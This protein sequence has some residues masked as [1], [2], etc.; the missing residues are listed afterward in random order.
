MRFGSFRYLLKEG[1]R[2]L[3]AN[4]LMSLA[5]VGVLFACLLM[6]GSFILLTMNM[7]GII[8]YMEDQ[9][10]VI[11]FLDDGLSGERIDGIGQQLDLLDNIREIVFVSREEGLAQQ[12]EIFGDDREY[13]QALVDEN[14]IP[15][16][17]RIQIDDLSMLDDTLAKIGRIGGIYEVSAP[18]DVAVIVSTL[19][20]AV[21]AIGTAIIAVLGIVSLLIV[22]NTIKIT[23]FNRR[24]EINIMKYVGATNAF[25]RFP[26]LIEGLLLGL[27]A[28]LLAYFVLFLG[29]DTII[30]WISGSAENWIGIL[31]AEVIPFRTVAKPMLLGFC[32]GSAGIGALGSMVFI[33]KYL[34]A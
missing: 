27:I 23:V 3:W 21:Y 10:E 7:N 11:I 8:G 4:R 19:K 25:V 1:V 17:F 31:G 6:I 16:S 34:K 12:M 24:K 33:R 14:P 29:Y 22:S 5:S 20:K 18:Q 9:N 32:V 15:D 30:G 13:F 28:G 2:G 26:F